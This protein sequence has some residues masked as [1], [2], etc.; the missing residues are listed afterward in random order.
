MPD[1]LTPKSSA[2]W[3]S[4]VVG[5]MLLLEAAYGA[6][7]GFDNAEGVVRATGG[8]LQLLGL[9]AVG[10]GLKRKHE[11]H[12]TQAI[13]S[14]L[15]QELRELFGTSARHLT[16][17]ADSGEMVVMMGKARARVTCGSGAPIE[18][19]ISRLENNVTN[20]DDAVA[21]VD[22]AL[23]LATDEWKRVLAAEDFRH[24]ATEQAIAG[25]IKDLAVGDI[26]LETAG[27]VWML[28]GTVLATWSS[29]L[30]R[31]LAS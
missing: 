11:K 31:F 24:K 21:T 3:L 5:T 8:V 26:K 9:G 10:L 20:L 23:T 30:G 22:E 25:A 17:N 13:L 1:A 15:L 6:L 18:E 14:E 27:F 4:Y 12:S 2:P 19:R 29:G 7:L 28:V 16:L